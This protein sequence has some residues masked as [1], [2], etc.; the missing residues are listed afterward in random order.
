[1]DELLCLAELLTKRNTIERDIATIMGFDELPKIDRS[2]VQSSDSALALESVFRLPDFVTRAQHPDLGVDYDIELAE[3]AQGSNIHFSVQLKSVANGERDTDGQTLKFVIETS[4]L[5]Y[6]SR[7][8]CGSLLVIY[9]ASNHN[10]FYRWVHEI[11][12]ELDTQ[13]TAWRGQRSVTVRLSLSNILNSNSAKTIHQEV[14]ILYRRI[15][16]SVVEAGLI[17]PMESEGVSAA[18]KAD[19]QARAP[20]GEN[21]LAMLLA[22][23]FG[24]VSS[25]LYRQVIDAYSQTP[26]AEWS[27]NPK[28]LLTIAYAYE[29]AGQPL[30]VLTYSKAAL[31]FSGDAKLSPTDASFAERMHLSSRYDIGLIGHEQY[32]AEL[33]AF[34]DRHPN[35][36]ESRYCHLELILRDIVTGKAAIGEDPIRRLETLYEA[37]KKLVDSVNG[38]DTVDNQWG[39]HFLLARIEFHMRDQLIM[40]ANFRINAAERMGHPIPLV[41]RILMARQV[42][43]I[44]KTA[45]D[46]LERLYKTAKAADRPDLCAV[47][48]CEIAS[49]Q[50]FFLVASHFQ[51]TKGRG[52][53]TAEQTASLENCLSLADHAVKIFTQL[54]NDVLRIR[55]ARLKADI[56]N[57]LGR[58]EEALAL[59]DSLRQDLVRAGLNPDIAQITELPSEPSA[60][61]I[62]QMFDDATDA[63]LEQFARGI[64]RSLRIPQQRI[65][66]VLKDLE[67]GKRIR[68]ERRSW[69]KHLELLQELSHTGSRQTFYS[70]D[71]NRHCKCLRY[72]YESAIGSNDVEAVITAFK[73]TFCMGCTGREIDLK[74]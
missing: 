4:R 23:G 40:D 35:T 27:N 15:Q 58:R 25:G 8:L 71:P 59:I 3:S 16:Q 1:M 11:V 22:S 6:L 61:D 44:A 74:D 9:D 12:S 10:M 33:K 54:E 48:N 46:R 21:I 30:Q 65:G 42:L 34:I 26:S 49:N 2:R 56:L 18:Q 43:P 50:L 69:C 62:D 67:S 14:G 57:T 36:A 17:P 64:I 45:F 73:A 41:E 24:L 19:F 31:T 63:D 32:V 66:N 5:H 52:A 29:H 28:H 38:P 37:A 51:L 68:T 60:T 47:C 7:T 13:G 53:R 39:L 55:G 20:S 70:I 72:S